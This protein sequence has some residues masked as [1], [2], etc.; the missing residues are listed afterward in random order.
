MIL[1]FEITICPQMK[2]STPATE[3]TSKL[4]QFTYAGK[5][6]TIWRV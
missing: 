1:R 4:H 2:S 3:G 6:R 5:R